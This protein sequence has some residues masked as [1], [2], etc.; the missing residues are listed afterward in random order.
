MRV[1]NLL[2]TVKA[3]I[4]RRGKTE[5]WLHR[6]R[7]ACSL[8]VHCEDRGCTSISVCVVIQRG[9]LINR[10]AWGWLTRTGPFACEDM[11]MDNISRAPLTDILECDLL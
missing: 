3:F 10:R 2:M 1:T 4:G 8:V 7:T 5:T 6:G 9:I 11:L